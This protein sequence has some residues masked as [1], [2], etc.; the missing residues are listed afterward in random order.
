MSLARALTTI[1]L[2]GVLLLAGAVQKSDPPVVGPADRED[3]PRIVFET[4]AVHLD[5]GATPLAA[6]Q[7]EITAAAS[8]TGRVEIVGIEGGEHPLLSEPPYYDPAAMSNDRVIL[9]AFTT[10]PAGDLPRGD[11]R[12][13]TLHLRITGAEAPRFETTLIVGADAEGAAIDARITCTL[14][15]DE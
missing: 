14:G 5:T 13:A 12:V 11:V 8:D 3:A 9:A 2:T 1:G 6:Y 10:A 15:R 4:L 7:I